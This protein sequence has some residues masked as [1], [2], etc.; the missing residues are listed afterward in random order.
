MKIIQLLIHRLSFFHVHQQWVTL[1]PK[2]MQIIAR[3][4]G[5]TIAKIDKLMHVYMWAKFAALTT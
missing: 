1:L 2:I 4:L 3:I 5:G